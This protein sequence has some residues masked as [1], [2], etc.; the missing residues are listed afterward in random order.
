[1]LSLILGT[2]RTP[3]HNKTPLR[4]NLCHVV[5]EARFFSVS[6]P[7]SPYIPRSTIIFVELHSRKLP[8]YGANGPAMRTSM[9]RIWVPVRDLA[10]ALLREKENAPLEGSV[11]IK[12]LVKPMAISY[13]LAWLMYFSKYKSNF[14]IPPYQF[15]RLNTLVNLDF[16]LADEPYS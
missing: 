13:I 9:Y 12:R 15:N 7:T 4:Q 2:H 6:Q 10:H 5:E 14:L 3:S 16:F 1:M 11:Q 8:G